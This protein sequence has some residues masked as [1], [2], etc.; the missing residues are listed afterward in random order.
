MGF[1]PS[2][3]RQWSLW[4]YSA[5]VAGW[6]AAHAPPEKETLEPPS[7]DTLRAMKARNAA[8]NAAAAA[9]READ[10]KEKASA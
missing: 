1:S 4:E 2:E 10:E 9:A 7:I 3:S 5:I 6:N 8:E